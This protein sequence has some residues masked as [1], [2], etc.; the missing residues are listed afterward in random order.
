MALNRLREPALVSPVIAEPKTGIC[1]GNWLGLFAFS[2]A[3]A[4]ICSSSRRC[5]A[6][7]AAIMP[8]EVEA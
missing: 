2:R 1:C 6:A 5:R 7:F 3:A 4:A 8:F